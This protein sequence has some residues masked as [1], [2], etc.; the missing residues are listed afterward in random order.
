M[1]K[2]PKGSLFRFLLAAGLCGFFLGMTLTTGSEE[3]DGCGGH[4][5]GTLTIV[6]ST[7]YIA[8]ISLAGPIVFP[9]E[10]IQ[11]GNTISMKIRAGTY[12]WVVNFI[13]GISPIMDEVATGVVTVKNDKTSTITITRG[14]S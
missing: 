8:V 1:G 7:E 11:P 12:H 6:N 2:R 14:K 4:K 9:T 3:T 5:S 13:A 10:T